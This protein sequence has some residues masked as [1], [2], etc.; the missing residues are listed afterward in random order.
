MKKFL[1]PKLLPLMAVIFSICGIGL[2]L[3]TLGSGPNAAGLYPKQT[4]AWIVLLLF[5]ALAVTWI[6]LTAGRL[7]KTGT[8]QESYPASIIG[9]LGI[10]AGSIAFV[11][12]G[13]QSL[14]SRG[15]MLVLLTGVLGIAAGCA[16]AVAAFARF[17][18]TKPSAVCHMLPCLFMAVRI[19]VLCRGWSNVT[20]VGVF[21]FPF[22]ASL[23]VMLAL[24][25]R[26]LFDVELGKRKTVVFWNLT[27]VYLCM[28]A[29]LANTDALL[30]VTLAFWH[31]ADLCSLLPMKRP[32]PEG[33]TEAP[34]PAVNIDIDPPKSTNPEDMTMDELK[35]W[36]EN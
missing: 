8:Y 23:A 32:A 6:R 13:V 28:V 4:A 19:F 11:I 31:M 26:S 15:N 35:E 2:R 27:A 24:Y 18:G 30:Y 7:K 1:N 29:L 22:L 12:C 36:L 21:L 10:L 3:W 33:P 17:K 16:L 20:Q 9:A 34:A 14:L 5:S 25:Q